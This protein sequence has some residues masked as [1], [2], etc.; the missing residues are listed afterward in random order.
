MC[1]SVYIYIYTCTYLYMRYRDV[2]YTL[3]QTTQ[4]ETPAMDPCKGRCRDIKCWLRENCGNLKPCAWIFHA[5]PT[6]PALIYFPY[7]TPQRSNLLDVVVIGVT[8]QQ[9]RGGT[10]S[11]LKPRISDVQALWAP[12][13]V[14][15]MR[16]CTSLEFAQQEAPCMAVDPVWFCVLRT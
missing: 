10:P 4:H 5:S 3:P 11:L 9:Q 7:R 1:V 12:C 14:A 8:Q 13:K 6:N 2:Y 15:Y 16:R